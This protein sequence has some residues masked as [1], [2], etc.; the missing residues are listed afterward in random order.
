MRLW[1]DPR[2]FKV[3]VP[4]KVRRACTWPA[5]L[6]LAGALGRH[7][8]THSEARALALLGLLLK[9]TE[10]SVTKL[11]C[12]HQRESGCDLDHGLP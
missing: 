9:R 12:W 1:P 7:R 2:A 3:T 8:Q 4:V 6:H 11:W 5:C 10:R